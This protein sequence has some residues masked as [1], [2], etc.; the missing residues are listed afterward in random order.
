MNKQQLEKQM[1]E[2]I[3]DPTVDADTKA[4][5]LGKYINQLSA[6]IASAISPISDFSA[7]FVVATLELYAENVRK[8]FKCSESTIATIKK[9]NSEKITIVLPNDESEEA[10]EH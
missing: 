1:V 4:I 3:T 9:T 6:D 8:D 2:C 10:D 5:I 7:T